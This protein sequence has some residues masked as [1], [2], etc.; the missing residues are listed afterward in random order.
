LCGS[1]FALYL[2]THG[3]VINTIAKGRTA[4]IPITTPWP[5]GLPFAAILA[6]FCIGE[7][8]KVEVVIW[9]SLV[10]LLAASIILF[11]SNGMPFALLA[12][13]LGALHTDFRKQKQQ[14]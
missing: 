12:I 6:L 4:T 13:V 7:L 9:C 5:F 3:Q 11:T 2:G 14:P 10:V 1:G 8:V